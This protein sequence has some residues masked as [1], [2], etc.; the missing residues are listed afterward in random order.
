MDRRTQ[1]EEGTL[2][3]FTLSSPSQYGERVKN[4]PKYIRNAF[5]KAPKIDN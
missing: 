5:T 3:S 1:D 2:I 4:M